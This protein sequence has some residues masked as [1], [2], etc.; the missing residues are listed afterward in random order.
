M[1][2]RTQDTTTNLVMDPVLVWGWI[3]YL[4][5]A[6]TDTPVNCWFDP[7]TK[8]PK[9]C[10]IHQRDL[11]VILRSFCISGGRKYPL[12]YNSQDISTH[13]LCPGAAMP[14]FLANESVVKI[15]IL[16]CWSS[17]AFMRYIH[18]EVMEWQAGLSQSMLKQLDFHHI[19]LTD[20]FNHTSLNPP[21]QLNIHV[22]INSPEETTFNGRVA[23]VDFWCMNLEI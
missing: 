9:A 15:M 23:H 21:L 3:F 12:R 6:P 4:P 7:I 19:V 22:A 8:Q 18:S 14:L 10:Y 20:S 1:E 13:S 2:S 5:H 11:I 17:T 16:G